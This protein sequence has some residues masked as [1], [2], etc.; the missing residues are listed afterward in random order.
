MSRKG[1]KEVTNTRER[2]QLGLLTQG[3][4]QAL[5]QCKKS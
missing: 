3:N 5:S 1:K 2:Q 4:D